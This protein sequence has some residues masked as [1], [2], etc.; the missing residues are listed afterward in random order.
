MTRNLQQRIEVCAP[1]A[2]ERLKE[3]LVNYFDIQWND[4]VKAVTL[5]AELNQLR[6]SHLPE[7]DLKCPQDKIYE[8]LKQ[9]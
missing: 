6:Q 3:Q 5:D 2:E 1:I 9:R 4:K 8:Y 7:E